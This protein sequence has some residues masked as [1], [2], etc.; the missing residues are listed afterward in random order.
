ML[1]IHPF[2]RNFFK[3][4]SQDFP[5]LMVLYI[6]NRKPQKE[7]RQPTTSITFPHLVLLALFAS[8]VDYAEQFLEENTQLPRLLNLTIGYESL[9]IATNNFTNNA[10]RLT[11]AKLTSLKID[12]P[13]VRPENFDEYFSLL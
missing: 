13:F 8:H 4:I 10:T 2:E 11:C 6:I 1:D 12:E 5:F 3:V 7:K 9:A